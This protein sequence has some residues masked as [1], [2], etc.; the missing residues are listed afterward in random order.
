MP[1]P[2]HPQAFIRHIARGANS[3]HSLHAVG[4]LLLL[5]LRWFGGGNQSIQIVLS[6][7][8]PPT[9]ITIQHTIQR[10]HTRTS[11][12]PASMN[13]K[14]LGSYGS[15]SCT[16][17]YSIW[18]RT[19]FRFFLNRVCVDLLIYY[20]HVCVCVEQNTHTPTRNMYTHIHASICKDPLPPTHPP[21]LLPPRR[22]RLAP[23]QRGIVRQ[24]RLCCVRLLFVSV[25][26]YAFKYIY[27]HVT[28]EYICVY[29]R[30]T[31]TNAQKYPHPHVETHLSQRVRPP[32]L[33]A[34]CRVPPWKEAQP[35]HTSH[36]HIY[37]EYLCTY[38]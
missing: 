21:L 19:L 34:S 13:P 6:F 29:D 2:R 12:T 10:T 32:L 31:H 37:R 23:R 11:T 5:L 4:A 22:L 1:Q 3:H 16:L 27:I 8:P 38:K 36:V 24:G 7:I 15:I 14:V 25:Y 17:G 33:H 35:S 30:L 9:H 28:Y 20:M 26:I 18:P